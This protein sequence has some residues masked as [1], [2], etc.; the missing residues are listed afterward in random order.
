MTKN[1][2]ERE[3]PFCASQLELKGVNDHW[4]VLYCEEC[5]RKMQRPASSDLNGVSVGDLR[6]LNQFTSTESSR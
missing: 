4:L 5:D 2:T 3:C 1:D 6:D